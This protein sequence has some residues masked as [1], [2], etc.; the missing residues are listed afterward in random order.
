MLDVKYDNIYNYFIFNPY[1]CEINS[2]NT[3]YL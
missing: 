3:P 2:Y 1:I